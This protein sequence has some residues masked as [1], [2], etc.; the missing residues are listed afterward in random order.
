MRRRR[1]RNW[2]GPVFALGVACGAALLWML[3]EHRPALWPGAPAPGVASVPVDAPAERAAP[4]QADPRSAG[5]VTT[6]P[7]PPRV[8]APTTPDREDA[9]P[10]VASALPA[11]VG[12]DA[13][14]PPA[15]AEPAIALPASALLL[16]VSGVRAEDLQDTY[17]D[18]RG[19][20]RR[21]DA[22]DIMA[23][24]G[25]PVLAVDDGT[26]AKLFNSKPG[27]LTIYQFDPRAEHAYYYAHLDRYA[28][29]L[30]EGQ[31]VRRGDVIG[32]VGASG[33]ANPA[34]PHLH[35]AIFLLGP[36]KN[37]WQGT[38]VNP[39]ALLGGVPARPS[40]AGEH[41]PGGP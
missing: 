8:P 6:I 22:I 19:D 27:G 15:G 4:A 9:V 10:P 38:P 20:G 12:A 2:L 32:F 25:T 35:F 1:P 11:A 31:R 26:I 13:A 29:G 28:D 30:R 18:A 40:G 21:H 3:L 39:Y 41:S 34:A 17:A 16:P 7:L 23:P 14:A 24:T 37:W 5:A 33:N 36:E